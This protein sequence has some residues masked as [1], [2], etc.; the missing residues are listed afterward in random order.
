PGAPMR[1]RHLA[2]LLATVPLAAQ[3]PNFGRTMAS[4]GNELLVGQPVN[5]Y[6]P[7][8]VYSYRIGSDG[9]WHEAARITAG[10]AE[11]MDDFGR[12]L[13]M[14]GNTLA[15]AAPRK[16]DGAGVVYLF[17]RSSASA[18]W[19]E[20]QVIEAPDGGEFGAALMLDGDELL[21]GAPGADSVGAVHHFRRSGD[22]WQH[23]GDINPPAGTTS[24]SG[25]GASLF[26]DDNNLLIGAPGM[27]QALGGRSEERR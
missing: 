15:V 23:T 13:A 24:G 14:D 3:E 5:W 2:L 9:R 20:Q 12:A 7:G 17:G 11:R 26:L 18:P 10:D 19:Q 22:A 1:L 25:F 6:G 4:T 27:D 16:R 8:T 21:V